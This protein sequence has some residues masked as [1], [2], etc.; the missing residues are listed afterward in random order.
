V[1]EMSEILQNPV[2]HGIE[3]IIL[4]IPVKK[5]KEIFKF[6]H[7]LKWEFVGKI[8]S[9]R[10]QVFNTPESCQFEPIDFICIQVP[11]NQ[12]KTEKIYEFGS[13][14]NKTY[15]PVKRGSLWKVLFLIPSIMLSARNL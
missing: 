2:I 8:Y 3:Q 1:L 10:C 11:A 6:T 7:T 13:S 14:G 9:Q 5:V 12:R 4:Q 15:N